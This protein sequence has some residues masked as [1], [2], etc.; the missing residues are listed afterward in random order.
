[1]KRISEEQKLFYTSLKSACSKVSSLDKFG[2]GG[3]LSSSIKGLCGY[4]LAEIVI[5]MLVIAVIVAVTIGITKHKL[6]NIVTYTYYSAYSSLRTATSQ[7]LV[8]YDP[9]DDRYK[10]NVEKPS[11]LAK[12][13]VFF[14]SNF[15]V[16][17]ANAFESLQPVG[18]GSACAE[19]DTTTDSGVAACNRN[20]VGYIGFGMG[21]TGGGSAIINPNN[22]CN[23]GSAS[24]NGEFCYCPTGY[25]YCYQTRSCVSCLKTANAGSG[26]SGGNFQVN[27][28]PQ[29][30]TN[31]AYCNPPSSL[32]TTCYAATLDGHGCLGYCQKTGSEPTCSESTKPNKCAT[33]LAGKWINLYCLMG[34]HMD[35]DTCT[36]V[37]DEPECS[38]GKEWN[39]SAC[40]C[41]SGKEDVNGTCM[42]PCTGGKVR[43]SSGTCECPS[44][45][46][47][48]SGQCVD[49]CTGG[50][51][52]N[53][54]GVCSCPSGMEEWSGKCVAPCTGGKVRNSSGSCECPSGKEEWGGQ[55]MAPCTG[56]KTRNSSG[57]CVC[58]SGK[59][60]QNGTCVTPNPNPPTECSGGKVWNGS[61]CVCPS[62]KQEV[63]GECITPS[64]TLGKVWNGSSCV[65]PADKEEWLGMCVSPCTGGKVRNTIGLCVCPSGTQ[66][67]NGVCVTPSEPP[68][69]TCSGGKYWN[70]SECVCPS[71]QVDQGGTCVTP[72]PTCSGGQYWNG[73][74]C[75]CPSDEIWN[76]SQCVYPDYD[77]TGTQ[78]CGT[79]CDRRTGTWVDIAGFSREC[80]EEQNKVWSETQCSCIPSPR[81]I[82]LNGQK[83]CE[84][85][86]SLFNTHA[87]APEC[88]G[89]A[90]GSNETSFSGKTPDITLRNGMLLYNVRQN[91]QA[92][93]V[94]ANNT[95][96]STA[97]LNGVDVDTNRWGYTV[98]I[99]IDGAKSGS[100]TLWEDVYPFYVTLGGMVIPGYDKDHPG[101]YGGDSRNHMQV[102]LEDEV[103]ENGRRKIKWLAKSVSYKEAACA[104]GYVGANTPYCREGNAAVYN[105]ECSVDNS[106]CRLKYI[107]PVKFLF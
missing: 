90:I 28:C 7:M 54:A 29:G 67:E 26:S 21:T 81:T 57:I 74:A 6:D 85:L 45:K 60:D 49:P 77:C 2:G 24:P 78:P 42:D 30:G 25:G 83:Y 98:Y 80:N 35:E 48:W 19:Y 100:S 32:G 95:T 17:A 93:A 99:D 106:L 92:L 76:G 70:G 105:N 101:Q 27:C 51:I 66:E 53:S 88:T 9:K 71:G 52:R 50:K 44:G 55:C 8:D 11:I 41:P 65:C 103:I 79:E 10:A 68:T 47:E 12:A 39:G 102:S 5:V 72:T 69:P 62:D 43:N 75:V 89:S 36:C 46:E 22:N 38:G 73:S 58:P 91:P 18:G 86:V 4:T 56:G 23:G 64:C 59:I 97:V 1:M 13:R 16:L 14:E 107:K 15:G 61:S 37:K 84:Y 31:V 40:V 87:N 104:A 96:G 94:L 82:T 3:T 33:C 63:N 34:Q 20:N